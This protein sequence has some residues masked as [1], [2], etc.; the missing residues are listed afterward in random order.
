MKHIGLFRALADER[1]D[2]VTITIHAPIPTQPPI[3][4]RDHDAYFR[5]L[6]RSEGNLLA[7]TLWNALPGGS[8]DALI[9][10]LLERRASL[11]QGRIGG[12][13]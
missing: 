2:D 10:A 12:A 1:V 13:S 4:L 7:D 11:L 6:Y 3:E 8:L 9:V 5:A